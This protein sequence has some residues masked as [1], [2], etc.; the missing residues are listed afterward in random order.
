MKSRITF[1]NDGYWNKAEMTLENH[2]PT[3]GN[4]KKVQD[5]CDRLIAKYSNE[6][7]CLRHPEQV[8]SIHVHFQNDYVDLQCGPYDTCGCKEAVERLIEI[9]NDEW[10]IWNQKQ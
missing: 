2:V 1:V 9:R 5:F 10:V 4:L 6:K 8:H 3:P 7:G